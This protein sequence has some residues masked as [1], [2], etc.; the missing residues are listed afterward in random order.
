MAEPQ[1]NNSTDTAAASRE[2]RQAA[3]RP[4]E[5][6]TRQNEQNIEAERRSFNEGGEAARRAGQAGAEAAREVARTAADTT[7]QLGETGRRVGREAV[8]AWRSALDPFATTQLEMTRWFDDMWRQLAG[9]SPLTSMHAARPFSGM[10]PA[11]LFGMP[12]TDIRE[13]P[14]AYQL[15]VEL[16]GLAREDVDLTISGDVLTLRGHKLED[17]TH[18][19]GAYRVSERRYGRFER[20]FPLPPDVDHNR[21]DATF[22]DGLLSLN[23]PRTAQAG[24]REAKIPIK[25]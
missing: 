15:S 13:T 25:G 20:S 4:A 18:G 6:A 22:K 8:Q 2:A 16:P 9:F 17:N 5:A 12:A 19:Q 3:V 14:D 1:Q 7:R 11:T 24:P 10:G 21:L 23:L